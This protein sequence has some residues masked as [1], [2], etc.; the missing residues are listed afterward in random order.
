MSL[1]RRIVK[2]RK[3]KRYFV[4]SAAFVMLGPY[5]STGRRVQILD[6]SEGGA[7]FIYNG[8]KDELEESGYLSLLAGDTP[9]LDRVDFVTASDNDWAVKPGNGVQFRRRGVQFRWLGVMDQR[10]LK[11]FIQETAVVPT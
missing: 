10:R 1:L 4:N 5:T 6:I 8:S 7:A 3:H 2:P 11:E 9:Y